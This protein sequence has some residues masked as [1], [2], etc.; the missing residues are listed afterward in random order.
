MVIMISGGMKAQNNNLNLSQKYITNYKAEDKDGVAGT[1][2][3]IKLEQLN[4]KVIVKV[5]KYANRVV[6]ERNKTK[7]EDYPYFLAYVPDKKE[8]LFKYLID[9]GQDSKGIYMEM[10][11]LDDRSFNQPVKFYNK[12]SRYISEKQIPVVEE[13]KT[14]LNS[15]LNFVENK[16]IIEKIKN[17]D[18]LNC[19]RSICKELVNN[20]SQLDVNYLP[21]LEFPEA[22]MSLN[23]R[24]NYKVSFNL[25]NDNTLNLK[26]NKIIYNS[27]VTKIPYEPIRGSSEKTLFNSVS[28]TSDSKILYAVYFRESNSGKET[29]LS[30]NMENG[31][32]NEVISGSIQSFFIIKEGKYKN[33]VLTAVYSNGYGTSY[34]IMNYKGDTIKDLGMFYNFPAYYTDMDKEDKKSSQEK[35]E[36]SKEKDEN[37]VLEEDEETMEEE[38]TFVEKDEKMEEEKTETSEEEGQKTVVEKSETSAEKNDKSSSID[39]HYIGIGSGY[40]TDYGGLGGQLQFA[41][42]YD[43][44][45]LLDFF[46][47]YGKFQDENMFVSG[48]R[49]IYPNNALNILSVGGIGIK[50]QT[51][52]ITING[53]TSSE[54][55]KN[56]LIGWSVLGGY[57]LYLNSKETFYLEIASGVSYGEITWFEGTS[58]EEEES[59]Y[60]L[61]LDLSLGYLI[62][63]KD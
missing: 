43:N 7:N 4:N 56:V 41:W 2:G 39:K 18:P 12:S 15:E 26:E 20:I 16:D 28:I 53:H 59:Y 50:K 55:E 57:R 6:I 38:K 36:T 42:Q 58:Y 9:F 5:L 29:L 31:E 37:T 51:T 46:F 8:G 23:N 61:A 19:S 40:G 47:S 21:T 48:L 14:S 11:L 35:D 25:D 17:K 49:V 54:T 24:D 13:Y 30:Y 3:Y 34:R 52:S 60:L 62:K 10:A 45:E 44:G 33:K 32:Y 27:R 1:Y 22:S 63:V